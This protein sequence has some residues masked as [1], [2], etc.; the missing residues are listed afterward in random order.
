MNAEFVAARDQVLRRVEEHPADAKLLSTLG[1]I[2]AYL[3][4]KQDA[5]QETK[6][7]V[8]ILPVSKDAVDGPLLVVNLEAVYALTNEPDLAFPA[9]DVSIRTPASGISYG[10]LKLD[11]GWDPLRSDPRF[12]KLVAQL[13]P[14]E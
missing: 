13:A 9:L 1:A 10:E 4:R 3:G 5:I 7:A 14:K 12:D 11:P 8:E 6:R 2:D